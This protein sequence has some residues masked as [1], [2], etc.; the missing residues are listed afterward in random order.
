MGA[1]DDLIAEA[2]TSQAPAGGAFAD[3]IA[4]AQKAPPRIQDALTLPPGLQRNQP[5]T[6]PTL[7]EAIRERLP[8]SGK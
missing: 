8:G 4:E 2:Q 6:G 1:F 5:Y 7:G 3:L